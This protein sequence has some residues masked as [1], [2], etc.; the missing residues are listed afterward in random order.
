MALPVS[1][2]SEEECAVCRWR[3]DEHHPDDWQAFT[4]WN[5][6][7]LCQEC[8]QYAACGVGVIV[9]DPEILEDPIICDPEINLSV[10]A[11]QAVVCSLLGVDIPAL[12]QLESNDSDSE[13]VSDDDSDSEYE[14]GSDDSTPEV[15]ACDSLNSSTA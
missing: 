6:H 13:S 5:A 7:L 9:V 4:P 1:Y 12:L 8:M 15:G 2:V 10:Q 11:V 14:M 3:P